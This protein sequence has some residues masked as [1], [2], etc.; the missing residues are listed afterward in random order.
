MLRLS[1]VA[2]LAALACAGC[3][4]PSSGVDGGDLHG[5]FERE[6]GPDASARGA[7]AEPSA[8]VPDAGP[9]TPRVPA[10]RRTAPAGPC[11]LPDGRARAPQARPAGRPACRSA[12]V[13]EWRDRDGTPRYGCVLG[14][15]DAA[16]RAPLPLLVFF[17]GEDDS[18][19]AVDRK[20]SL[21]RQ[22]ARADLS[23]DPRRQGFLVLAPQGR[24]LEPGP[25]G[26][27]RFDADYAGPDNADALAVDHFVE[28]LAAEGL[29]DRRRIYAVGDSAGGKMAALYAA[30]RPASIAAFAVY[31]TDGSGAQWSCASEPPPAAIVYRACD[32]VTPCEQVERWLEQR[33]AA[34]AATFALRLGAEGASLPNCVSRASCK[35]RAARAAHAR[36]PKSREPDVLDYLARYTLEPG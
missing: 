4:M 31:G 6:V 11:V 13:L 25:D 19:A 2:T 17:H 36:W 10:L 22:S 3:D 15:R 7:P 5:V 23:G 33:R 21:R 14:P 29:V 12:R 32:D 9:A 16:E 35:A 8:A 20:T 30:L 1:V 34:G 26:R 28:A 18:P 24:R 27:L